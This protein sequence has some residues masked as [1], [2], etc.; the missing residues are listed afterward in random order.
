MSVATSDLPAYT[1]N[2]GNPA[3]VIRQR[4]IASK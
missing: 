1:I 3:I 4:E 2:K